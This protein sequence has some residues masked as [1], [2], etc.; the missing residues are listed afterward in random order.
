MRHE[1]DLLSHAGMDSNA[2]FKSNRVP[3]SVIALTIGACI[4][5]SCIALLFQRNTFIG[6]RKA[7]QYMCLSSIGLIFYLRD[8]LDIVW[9]YPK[10]NNDVSTTYMYYLIAAPFHFLPVIVRSWRIFCVY[11]STPTLYCT[12]EPITSRRR[13]G[14]RWMLSRIF[15]LYIPWVITS[16]GLIW[17]PNIPYYTFIGLN[18]I[19]AIVNFVLTI[20]LFKMRMELRPKYLDETSSLVTYAVLSLIEWAFAN[21]VYIYVLVTTNSAN[22]MIYYIYIDMFMIAIMFSLTTGR[23]LYRVVLRRDILGDKKP[24]L[25]RQDIQK[26]LQRVSEQPDMDQSMIDSKEVRTTY[27]RVDGVVIEIQEEV[28]SHKSEFSLEMTTTSEI[29]S[30]EAPKV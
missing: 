22:I 1:R 23:L 18:G 3:V 28:E 2:D 15:A 27:R 29:E 24:E 26:A 12:M 20:L 21:S 19:A 8:S 14:H 25:G 5:A 11:R 13:R 16:L 17:D 7:V 30:D 9:T 10:Y 4:L 6:K